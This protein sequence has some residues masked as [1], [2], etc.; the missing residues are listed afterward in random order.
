MKVVFPEQCADDDPRQ[1]LRSMRERFRT[2]YSVAT[3]LAW[4]LASKPDALFAVAYEVLMQHVCPVA[5]ACAQF[6]ATEVCHDHEGQ[7]KGNR[8]S[9]TMPW[10]A[11]SV[12]MTKTRIV[13]DLA[14]LQVLV[15]N[16][17]M[18][19][20]SNDFSG[21]DAEKCAEFK[22]VIAQLTAI[23]RKEAAAGED[24]TQDF[25]RSTRAHVILL[26][27]LGQSGDTTE[28]RNVAL[29]DKQ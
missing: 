17:E 24:D 18:W 20:V 12:K 21:I 22:G 19:G 16:F 6:A 2:V 28:D 25:L 7:G 4:W 13:D 14:R 23:C 27:L 26:D 11:S 29:L 10:V 9:S 15:D 5:A 8:R 1:R 3:G